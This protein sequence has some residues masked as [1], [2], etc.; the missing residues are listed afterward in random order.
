MEDIT[1]ADHAHAKQI[2]R[3]FEIKYLRENHDLY[4]KSSFY[5]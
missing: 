3:H 4:V 1:D 2:C 5:F